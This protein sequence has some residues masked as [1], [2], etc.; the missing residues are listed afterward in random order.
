M[1]FVHS[2]AVIG[3]TC[4]GCNKHINVKQLLDN[5]HRT[6]K[7]K[8]NLQY[9]AISILSKPIRHDERPSRIECRAP[10]SIDR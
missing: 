4:V 5:V 7:K 8:D 10:N 6:D 3:M 1:H 9:G 2:H